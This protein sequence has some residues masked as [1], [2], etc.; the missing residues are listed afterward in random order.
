MRIKS[1]GEKVFS[2]VN[3]ALLALLGVAFVLP[4]VLILVMSFTS[5]DSYY[6][7][8]YSLFPESLTLE[9][10]RMIFGRGSE[11]YTAF[12][13]TLLITF[14]GTLI[15]LVCT[16]PVAYALSRKRLFGRRFFNGLIVFAMLF[17]GGLIPSFLLLASLNMLNTYW[18]IV[19]PGAL[20]PWYCILI[21]T[22]FMS[23]PDSLEESAKLDGAGHFTVLFRIV[24]PLALPSIATIGLFCA[25]GAWN[26]YFNALIY[27]NNRAIVPIQVYLREI[28]LNAGSADLNNMDLMLLVAQEAVRGATVFAATVPILLIYPFLQKYYVQGMTT[29]AIKE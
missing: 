9:G 24:L 15:G 5:T 14:L 18:S 12:Y 1:K 29:G 13:N 3:Y 21:R 2:V 19:V 11:I 26:E 4:Y 6:H 23:I 17:S 22:Y 25:V 28:L 10:Y 20:V 16:A 27:I 8:G 7:K